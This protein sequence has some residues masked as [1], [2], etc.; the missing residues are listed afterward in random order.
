MGLQPGKAPMVG[1]IET[2]IHS[3]RIT[4]NKGGAL[5]RVQS[6]TD[7]AA[8]TPQFV[9][10]AGL[11]AKS[12]FAAQAESWEDVVIA[13]PHVEETREALEKKLKE[14]IIVDRIAILVL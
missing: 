1:R 9:E 3:D 2:Y 8:K 12:A 14:K 4:A 7:F 5:I 11:A 10:F 13:F 6:D